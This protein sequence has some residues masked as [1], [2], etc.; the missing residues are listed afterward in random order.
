MHA[1]NFVGDDQLAEGHDFLFLAI[2]DGGLIFYRESALGP[3]SLEDSWTAYRALRDR[4]RDTP[5]EARPS[6]SLVVT[7]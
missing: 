2:P 3:G 6:L 7:G 4:D 5:T 1:I